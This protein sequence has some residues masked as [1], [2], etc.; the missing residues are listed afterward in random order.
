MFTSDYCVE[1]GAFIDVEGPVL[2]DNER[3]WCQKCKERENQTGNPSENKEP[4]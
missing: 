2:Y 3:V 1:C 4:S